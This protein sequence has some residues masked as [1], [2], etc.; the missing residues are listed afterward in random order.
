[1]GQRCVLGVLVTSRVQN[2][3]EVQRVLTECG[4][5]IK[6]RLGLHDTDATSC[7]PSGLILLELVGDEKAYAEVEAKLNTI[8]GLQ[9]QKMVFNM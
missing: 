2:V 3:P 6:T 9:I 4:C 1:M 5:Y 7:S 8:N